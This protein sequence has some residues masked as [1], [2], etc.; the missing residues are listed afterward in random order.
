[1]K[2]QRKN[3]GSA[4]RIQKVPF[5]H[6][7]TPLLQKRREYALNPKAF[8]T[9]EEGRLALFQHPQKARSMHGY[10]FLYSPSVNST[11]FV[12]KS[13]SQISRNF[14][15][16]KSEYKKTHWNLSVACGKRTN[17]KEPGS[18]SRH[19]FR[20]LGALYEKFRTTARGKQTELGC[21]QH[22]ETWLTCSETVGC[23]NSSN[24]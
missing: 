20:A 23:R 24:A 13:V 8:T 14:R 10:I 6:I 9:N 7:W 22:E 2:I 1:M 4:L 3:P 18:G 11:N 12:K 5:L 17:K 16:Q 21:S 15:Y 19:R